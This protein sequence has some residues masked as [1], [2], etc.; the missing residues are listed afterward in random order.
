MRILTQERLFNTR[1]GLRRKDDLLPERLL[2]E[3]LPDGPNKGSTVPLE[4]LKDDAYA[5]FGWD[6]STGIP[7][8]ELLKKLGITP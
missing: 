3:P 7:E 4:E 2:K 8:E 5:A 6:L 1:E